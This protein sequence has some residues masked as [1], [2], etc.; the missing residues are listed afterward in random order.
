MSKNISL[1]EGKHYFPECVND[2]TL[3][4]NCVMFSRPKLA[5]FVLINYSVKQL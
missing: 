2:V 1:Q 4:Q 3:F 5:S